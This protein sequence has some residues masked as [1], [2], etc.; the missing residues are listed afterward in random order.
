MY[1]YGDYT[2][3]REAFQQLFVNSIQFC[4]KEIK[5]IEVKVSHANRHLPSM[6]D[7]AK[8]YAMIM[9]SD[10]GSGVALEDKGKLFKRY[11]TTRRDGT[12]W[13]LYQVSQIVTRGHQGSITEHG[14]PGEGAMFWI[15]LP[16]IEEDATSELAAT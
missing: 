7:K 5:T 9:F 2:L 14:T 13:G 16:L 15:Y 1:V 4:D 10:N 8:R 3:L 12:G 11:F 6:L